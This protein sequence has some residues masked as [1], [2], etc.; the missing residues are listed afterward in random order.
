LCVKSLYYYYYHRWSYKYNISKCDELL[1]KTSLQ[2]QRGRRACSL[3]CEDLH[4]LSP[5]F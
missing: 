1:K 4:K 2:Q 3:A 5:W